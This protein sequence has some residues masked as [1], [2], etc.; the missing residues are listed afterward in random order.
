MEYWELFRGETKRSVEIGRG[1]EG[2]CVRDLEELLVGLFEGV[3]ALFEGD[4]VGGKFCLWIVSDHVRVGGTGPAHLVFGLTELLFEI[5]LCTAC[6]WDDRAPA[7]EIQVN[8]IASRY[9]STQ[10]TYVMF[11]PKAW[12][13]SM[14]TS[15]EGFP[16]AFC[17]NL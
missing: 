7:E 12:N 14:F 3:D 17:T 4:V 9:A 8:G 16:R 10:S 1:G 13:L 5:L 6:E 15:A 11:L 2:G